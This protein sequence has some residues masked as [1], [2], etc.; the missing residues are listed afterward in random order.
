MGSEN[1]AEENTF[2]FSFGIVAIGCPERHSAMV[3]APMNNLA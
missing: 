2:N 1:Q 3:S